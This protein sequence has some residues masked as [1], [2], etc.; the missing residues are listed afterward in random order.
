MADILTDK[1]LLELRSSRWIARL[2]LSLACTLIIHGYL[3]SQ[4]RNLTFREIS[5]EQGLSQSIVYSIIQDQKGFLW[6]GT[7]DGLN[8]WDGYTFKVF[9][10]DPSLPGSLSYNEIR[11]LFQ[12]REGTLWIGTFY[13]G[14]NQYDRQ[15]EQFTHYQHD[16]SNPASLSH[17][18]VTVIC[19][20]TE[21]ELWVGTDG[22]LNKL[23]R[24]SGTFT[25]YQH[26]PVDRK[27]I[28][29]NRIND[30]LVD[31]SGVLWVATTNG[32]CRFNR[33]SNTFTVYRHQE[34]QPDSLS[35][36]GVRVICEGNQNIL[37]IGTDS[38][39]NRFDKQT[40]KAVR[41]LPKSGDPHSISHQRIR[42][43]LIDSQGI[44]WIGTNGGGLNILNPRRIAGK[45]ARFIRYQNNP[46]DPN[47]L[48]HNEIYTI[49]ED[50]S[51][52]IWLGT[53]GGGTSQVEKKRKQFAHFKPEPNNPNS[54][55]NEIVWS[56]H[57]DAEGILWIG[58]HGGGLTRFDRQNNHY[59][60]YQHDPADSTTLS[61]NSV[62]LV[63]APPSNVDIF[64]IATNG[65]GL[66]KFYPKSG[67]F[68]RYLHQP[69]RPGS[70]SHN[71]LRSLLED[72]SGSLWIG[73]NGGGLNQLVRDSENGADAEFIHFR[74]DPGDP[75][76]LSNDFIRAIYEDKKEAG[77][78]LWIGTQG[79]GLNKFDRRTNRFTHFRVDR[80]NGN[81]LN[82]DYILSIYVDK[83]GV[84]WIGT[85]GGG[86]NK[87]DRRTMTFTHY[88]MA[89]GLPQNE[90]YGILE[91]KTGKLWISTNNGLSKFDPEKETFKNYNIHDGL[92]SN[93]FN[94]GSYYQSASGEMFFGGIRGYNAF[95]PEQIRDN[96]NVPTIVITAFLKFNKVV[97]LAQP[98]SDMKELVLS[99]RDRVFS[100][101][102]SA[103]DFT[104]PI[105]NKYA[106]KMEGLDQD[107][108]YTDANRR[109]ATY[110]TL[111]PGEYT[112]RV[113]GSN[114]DGIWNEEGVSLT[115]RIIPPFWKTGWFRVISVFLFFV[116]IVLFYRRRLRHIQMKIELQSAHIAQMSIMPQADPI[117]D[118]LD[119]SGVC[120]PAN[121]VGGDFFDYIWLKDPEAKL[122]IAVGDVSG[123]AMS[124]AMTAVMCA[125]MINS[126]ARETNSVREI[127]TKINQPL[128]LKTS[129]KVFIALC[130]A[131]FTPDK[132]E[133]IFTNAGLVKPLLKSA[134]AIIHLDAPGPKYPLAV[135][136][137]YSYE[138]KKMSLHSGDVMVFLTDGI[139]EA[140]NKN[141]ELYGDDRLCKLLDSI[142]T[143]SLS[144]G[145]IRK[146][147]IH[148]VMAFTGTA[149]QYD[150]MT[151]VVVKIN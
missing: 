129:K 58:T 70:I 119:V 113:K 120:I 18:N 126:K 95:F 4:Y 81:S 84:F 76:S 102:F 92:Q 99:Y 112:F 39:L 86:I 62:R 85:W 141:K 83:S 71:E 26:N 107:W 87:L 104:S 150:D 122:L 74:N 63:Y 31:S 73:T 21:G 143:P 109:F 116:L 79:G 61:H 68:V 59:R 146:E 15:S 25:R 142:D 94:G 40:G 48:S 20:G 50:R 54:L 6:F 140:Q 5:I 11:T 100:F 34:N 16:A 97:K 46:Q 32:L 77:R 29:D 145:E 136:Q 2:F 131:L 8:M 132:K 1:S 66:N 106:Y 111:A 69:E 28:S 27:S 49:F 36:N 30:L 121:E 65:G 127:A 57:E 3:L 13:G 37:W 17:N 60:H 88:T 96:P 7:E 103:L 117:V 14:L 53:Y 139:V 90:V 148:D 23:D 91:D 35:H 93:E 137:N 55:P 38:G 80:R 43:L 135:R 64:W 114:N 125:G 130:L 10:H 134:G 67:Q 47:S 22:G 24:G 118:G 75:E 56:F 72:R 45:R 123:K 9:R 124:A 151:V 133:L 105:K 101:E 44:L 19:E 33:Q 41:F 147:I 110:T 12:D 82:N 138:E 89:D 42:G 51:G 98:I 144:A 149:P 128:Y 78:F 52:I 115:V 108:V